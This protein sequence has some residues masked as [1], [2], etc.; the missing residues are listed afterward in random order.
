M[1]TD[2]DSCDVVVLFEGF[3]VGGKLTLFISL[4][5]NDLFDGH[6]VH[7]DHIF[8]TALLRSSLDIGEKLEYIVFNVLL[9]CF[10]EFFALCSVGPIF[11]ADAEQNDAP[12]AI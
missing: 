1:R 11:M 12:F 9:L 5:R 7:P 6:K 8:E 2:S 4:T 3:E 10:I